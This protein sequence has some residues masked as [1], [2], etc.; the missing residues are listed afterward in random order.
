MGAKIHNTTY[1]IQR[2]D[3]LGFIFRKTDIM[4]KEIKMAEKTKISIRRIT[5]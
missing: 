1:Y 2:Y 3:I 4:I 5:I